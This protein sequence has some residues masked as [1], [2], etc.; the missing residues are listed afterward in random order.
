MTARR[1]N[2]KCF[3]KPK[4]ELLQFRCLIEVDKDW[5]PGTD[6][7]GDIESWPA[8]FGSIS[9][10]MLEGFNLRPLDLISSKEDLLRLEKALHKKGRSLP[11]SCFIISFSAELYSYL[12]EVEKNFLHINLQL[13][14]KDGDLSV[15][16]RRSDD[17]AEKSAKIWFMC[18]AHMNFLISH[19]ECEIDPDVDPFVFD[20][21]DLRPGPVTVE[22]YQFTFFSDYHVDVYAISK[23]DDARNI[24]A[25]LC[26]PD[27]IKVGSIRPS[28]EDVANELLRYS[29]AGRT[30]RGRN[31]QQSSTS[32]L[33]DLASLEEQYARGPAK[34][35]RKKKSRR[36]DS[37]TGS[38]ANDEEPPSL[39]DTLSAL[40]NN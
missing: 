14:L 16:D 40:G 32:Q 9:V 8:T 35:R 29:S 36:N 23:S 7:D 39:G 10:T 5:Q 20:S 1:K 19:P 27:V 2:K 33:R 3:E 11:D 28:A 30:A 15:L 18:A 4:A 13:E 17:F 21:A 22:K 12:W 26:A 6:E 37:G 31:G 38:G 24:P 34:D 25:E